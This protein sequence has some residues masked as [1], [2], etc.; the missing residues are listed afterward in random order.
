MPEDASRYLRAL[1]DAEHGHAGKALETLDAL[2]RQHPDLA[3]LPAT[4]AQVALEA[5]RIDDA[6][7]RSRHQLR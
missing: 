3:M 6:I 2:S 1:I 7:T 5:G 4:A